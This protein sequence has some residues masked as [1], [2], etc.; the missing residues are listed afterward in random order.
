MLKSKVS[1]QE[2]DLDNYARRIFGKREKINEMDRLLFKTAK[3]NLSESRLAMNELLESN[4]E[5]RALNQSENIKKYA[6]ELHKGGYMWL[7]S[8]RDF[9][10]YF[11]EAA[12]F[13][14]PLLVFGESGTGKTELIRNAALKLTGQR[15]VV[16][17]S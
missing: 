3:K 11:E 7:P 4:A 8:R 5:L 15:L 2:N 9:L 14:R 12:L 16:Q 13:G 6:K 10:E 17:K 1:K